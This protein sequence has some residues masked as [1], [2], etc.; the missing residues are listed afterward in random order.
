MLKKS[1]TLLMSVFMLCTFGQKNESKSLF[2][3]FSKKLSA[4]FESNSQWYLNDT[5]FGEF[6]EDEHLRTTNF[7]RLDYD[8]SENFSAG[9]QLESYAPENLLNNSNLYDKDIGIAT[10]YIRY[11]TKKFDLILGH[12]Y[13][14][15]GS[16]LILRSWEDRNLGV[17][18]AI[19]GAKLVYF[20]SE[21]IRITTLH[22]RQRKGF[23]FSEGRIFGLDSEININNALSIMSES[24]LV[25]GLSYVGKKENYVNEQ[26]ESNKKIPE[27]INSFSARLDFSHKN[28]YSS[29]EYVGKS[30]DVRLNN[31]IPNQVSFSETQN[32]KGNAVSWTAGYSQ[33]GFGLSYNF[34]RLENMRFF[35]ERGFAN[36][37]NNPTNQLS[38]NY[39]PALNKQ[40]DYTLANI[41]LYQSQPGLFIENYENPLVKS[42]EI[43][44]FIDLFYN[45][46]KESV[47][48]GKYGTKINLNMSYWAGLETQYLDPNG[49]PFF[50]SDDLTYETEFL[51]FKNKLYSDL[52]LEIR[53]KWNRK[54]SSI[55]TYINFY[56]D[57]S[58]LESKANGKVVRAWIG[59][60]ES[61]YKFSR[62]KSIRLELQHLSTN[63]DARNWMG[64]TV[65]YFFN[66]K[67]GLY[68]NDS[69]NY[70]ESSVDQ[71]TKI[72]FFNAGISYAKGASR[73]A[74]NYGRQRGGL[75]CVGGICR[76]V[77]Q[78]T[79]LTLNFTTAF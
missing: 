54:L 69:Y 73:L 41:Y 21:D 58:Y 75:L 2:N 57:K 47:F 77:S 34:R 42:G 40:H 49:V 36:A 46:K 22:G 12:F 55:F 27:L 23:G 38:V 63:D 26:N 20:P 53:K 48:G 59:V 30:K 4:S 8:V 43:G 68:I 18:T 19:H 7:L 32:F 35:S 25:L 1:I 10:Y 71:D 5:K 78:N 51:N 70:E 64:G 79:G 62:G 76:P 44:Q 65:E 9:L 13:E 56:Y 66:S 17:N 67:F 60:A 61:T 39:L 74:L 14:Q 28:F 3:Q 31:I 11:R 24:S 29:L 33:K 15:F 6:E 72:H 50:V 37:V 52:N 45:F 16:G